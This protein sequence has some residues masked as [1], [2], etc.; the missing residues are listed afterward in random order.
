M[1]CAL[2]C[3]SRWAGPCSLA[4]GVLDA[5]KV[6][7]DLIGADMSA[8]LLS[9]DEARKSRTAEQY[10]SGV[11]RAFAALAAL[12]TVEDLGDFPP[13]CAV[14]AGELL[15]LRLCHVR[16]QHF[17]YRPQL[18]PGPDVDA[19]EDAVVAARAGPAGA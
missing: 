3:S 12:G 13:Y 16:R 11:M 18:L 9:E 5:R 6:A 15:G 17:T 8:G 19:T 4:V 10:Q 2:A 14:K 1:I 7:D